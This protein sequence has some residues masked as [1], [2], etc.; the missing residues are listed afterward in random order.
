MKICIVSPNYPLYFRRDETAKFAGAEVQAAFLGGAL[1]AEGH[2]VTFVVAN[3]RS[4]EKLP[5]PA[6]NAYGSGEGAPGLRFFHPRL[7]GV[8]R[9]LA[10]VDADVYYQ[11]N[12]SM[13]TGVTALFC[14]R[15][16]RVF[17]YG[18]GSD[19]DFSFRDARMDNLRDRV[20]FYAGLK[21]AHGVVVQ[22]E[23]QERS[24]VK[25]HEGPVRVIPNGIELGQ[26]DSKDPRETIAWI[27]GIRRIKQPEIFLELARRIGDR[28]FV[29]IGGGSG[30]EPSFEKK[31]L[32][33]AR[34]IPN[35][36]L[37][38]QIPHDAVRDY[39]GRSLVLVNTSR[40]EG[41]PNAYLEA[42][43][44][45][46]PV[47][48]FN[49]IDGIVER[50]KVGVICRGID[51]MESAVRTLAA[52]PGQRMS[53]GRRAREI[54]EARFSPQVLARRYLEFFEELLYRDA[55]ARRRLEKL[56]ARAA[57]AAAGRTGGE[58]KS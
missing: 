6:V 39:L 3:L 41:F 11:R 32:E 26:C 7:T 4:D 15:K 5:L 14:R 38:G 55:R 24:Y 47:V 19:T 28:R 57:G 34:G 37:T 30:V 23:Y 54:V 21:I 44:L 33:E 58:E 17:V 48:S 43:N 8:S 12:A 46:V 52:D 36:V 20:L 1:S 51:E 10:R 35:L 45:C 53:A 18:A 56:G 29:L 40:V 31:I 50:E 2:D 9:A 42:W 25:R 27:G 16:G 22:N 13:L 49:D